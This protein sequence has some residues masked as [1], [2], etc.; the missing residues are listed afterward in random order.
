MRLIVWINIL[1]L[2]TELMD[3]TTAFV[4]VGQGEL[5]SAKNESNIVS[6]KNPILANAQFE[7]T[8][9]PKNQDEFI[10]SSH[11]QPTSFVFSA[12]MTHSSTGMTV[13]IFQAYDIRESE[14]VNH[15]FK[16]YE[17]FL[18]DLERP[19]AV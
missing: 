12:V 13:F 3:P 15:Y 2:L 5:R 14:I 18:N 7:Q 4:R 16:V 10:E 9:D 11:A 6:L 19:P 8:Q 1:V 17:V